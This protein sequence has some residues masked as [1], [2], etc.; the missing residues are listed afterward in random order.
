VAELM[1]RV[2]ERG[3]DLEPCDDPQHSV[4]RTS[5]G[6]GVQVRSNR[7][8]PKGWIGSRQDADQIPNRILAYCEARLFEVSTR[9]TGR[10]LVR[11]SIA[12]ACVSSRGIRSDSSDFLQ[13]VKEP[14][15][16]D[17]KLWWHHYA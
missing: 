5:A 13:M 15:R 4:E 11:E 10:I 1:G 16:V 17:A 12:K 14:N 2:R 9:E 7:D 3:A 8:R 6:H